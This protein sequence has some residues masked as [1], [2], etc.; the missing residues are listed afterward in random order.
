MLSRR[1]ITAIVLGS[2]IVASIV[3]LPPIILDLLALLI[4]LLAAWEFSGF[5]KKWSGPRRIGYVI[6]LAAL[7]FLIWVTLDLVDLSYPVLI[8][9]ALWWLGAPF[10]L[11]RYTREYKKNILSQELLGVLIFIPSWLGLS[12]L[13]HSAREYL[14]YLLAIVCAADIGAYFAGNFFGKHPIAPQ[15]SPRKTIEGVYGG[16]V[17][18]LVV[19]VS[20]ILLLKFNLVWLN[21]LTTVSLLILSVVTCLW[22]IIG[23]LFESML[24]RMFG[25]KDSGNLLPGHGGFYDRIDS[26]TAATPIFVAGLF[27]I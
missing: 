13:N 8:M 26:L 21:S 25:I 23:D 7:A 16:I 6:F 27:L 10:F 15:I 3:Y 2:L 9:G 19:A 1:I 14:L 17:L 20:G 18:S 5:S 24:K 11:W 22:S 12:I 4:T